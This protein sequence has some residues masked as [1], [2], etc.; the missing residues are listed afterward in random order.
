M[1]TAA[2]HPQILS[3]S[4]F[5]QFPR[6]CDDDRAR[7]KQKL[8]LREVATA[9]II[10]IK[11]ISSAQTEIVSASGL[12]RDMQNGWSLAGFTFY[13]VFKLPL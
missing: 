4:I 11:R 5:H 2:V 9:R 1:D 7:F 10:E 12:A 6:P 3:F 8:V 13:G